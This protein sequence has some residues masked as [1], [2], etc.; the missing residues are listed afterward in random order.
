[1]YKQLATGLA[2]L[3]LLTGGTFAAESYAGTAQSDSV[4]TAVKNLFPDTKITKV[5]PHGRPFIVARLDGSQVSSAYVDLDGP[6][7]PSLLILQELNRD[8]GTVNSLL[9]FSHLPQP[10]S[11][12]PVK[13]SQDA[14]TASGKTQVEGQPVTVTY[15]ASVIGQTLC[16][17]PSSIVRSGPAGTKTAIPA[18]WATT[19]TPHPMPLPTAGFTV[20]DVSV[21]E[22]DVS[23]ELQLRNVDSAHPAVTGSDPSAAGTTRTTTSR[24]CTAG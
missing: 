12:D 23:V 17:R 10:T 9:W 16:V 18:S 11:L 1:M 22:N 5:E 4:R 20:R 8:N 2:A 14:Y 13:T 7:G 15:S 19:L 6:G 3:T 24:T 21:R